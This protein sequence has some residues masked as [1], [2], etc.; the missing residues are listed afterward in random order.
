MKGSNLHG[1]WGN[2]APGQ[3]V[4]RTGFTEN[5]TV[6]RSKE[7]PAPKEAVPLMYVPESWYDSGGPRVTSKVERSDLG[8]ATIYELPESRSHDAQP[9]TKIPTLPPFK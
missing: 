8:S 7:R 1:K 9:K 2:S 4:K 3:S 6:T 5:A